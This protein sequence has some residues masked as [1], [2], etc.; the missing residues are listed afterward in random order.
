MK[1][2]LVS[3]LSLLLASQ[4]TI[5]QQKGKPATPPSPGKAAAPAKTVPPKVIQL[6]E[7]SGYNYTKAGDN[8][9]TIPFQGKVFPQF[10]VVVIY[11]EGI[12]VTFGVVAEKKDLKVTPELMQK[13][14]R[15]NSDMDRVKIAIDDAGDLVVRI[16]SSLRVL[17]AEE[18]K[19]VVEQTASAT[20]DVYAAIKQYLIKPA[21]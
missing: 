16:D 9:W 18:F 6:L 2:W 10:N 20:D 19:A 12:I 11:I 17:D 1:K 3:S 13:L 15:L 4:L 14:L 21:K 7:A 8:V 5:A